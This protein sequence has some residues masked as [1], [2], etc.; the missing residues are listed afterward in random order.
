MKELHVRP[1]LF[2]PCSLSLDAFTFALSPVTF[3]LSL[4]TSTALSLERD[5]HFFHRLCSPS[6]FSILSV[7]SLSSSWHPDGR[8]WFMLV[9]MGKTCCCSTGVKYVLHNCQL[10]LFRSLSLSDSPLSRCLIN[11]LSFPSQTSH[12]ISFSS[13]LFF[14]FSFD[15]LIS[16]LPRVKITAAN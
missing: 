2:A 9:I 16:C 8:Q 6:S 3:S 13:P 15:A 5:T 4:N 1:L 11:L 7:L 10:S 14:L 12:I